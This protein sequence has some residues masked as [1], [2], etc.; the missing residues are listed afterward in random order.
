LEVVCAMLPG[1]DEPSARSGPGDRPG[2]DRASDRPFLPIGEAA[3]R[4]G[5]STDAIRRRL[6]RGTL[7]GEKVAGVWHVVLPP[8]QAGDTATA[9]PGARPGDD[10]AGSGPDRAATGDAT[11]ATAAL[12]DAQREEIAYL[13]SA[14]DA[15]REARRR[16]DT[17]IIELSRQVVALPSGVDA[18]QTQNQAPGRA[19]SA[20]MTGGCRGGQSVVL[21]LAQSVVD[22]NLMARGCS[23]RE[24]DGLRAFEM[25]LVARSGSVKRI[26]ITTTHQEASALAQRYL[27]YSQAIRVEVWGWRYH[28]WEL[29]GVIEPPTRP[30]AD[31]GLRLDGE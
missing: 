29:V 27:A 2:G 9:A 11:G 7:A 31:D 21:A 5:L 12:I 15:E 20:T 13:R 10:R 17:I 4:L 28:R 19:E 3:D 24:M 22:A 6:H 23:R 1:R 8:D 25:R 26:S 30:P 14:L 16:A 18:A